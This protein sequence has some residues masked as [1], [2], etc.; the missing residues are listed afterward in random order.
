[1]VPGPAP[2]G[3]GALNVSGSQAS[4]KF[5]MTS[6]D[7]FIRWLTLVP[8]TSVLFAVMPD[9]VI[10]VDGVLDVLPGPQPN[11]SSTKA[12]TTKRKGM[13]SAPFAAATRKRI[14]VFAQEGMG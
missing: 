14:A 2:A 13:S 12:T 4:I 6:P 1:Q 10:D 11:R 3:G 8:S 9:G 5:T 7:A